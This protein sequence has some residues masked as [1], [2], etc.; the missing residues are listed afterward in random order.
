[1]N[2]DQCRATV[3]LHEPLR[4][5]L[6][7]WLGG[8]EVASMQRC[9]LE[10]GHRGEHL[11]LP[12]AEG[13]GSFRWDECGFHIGS[14]H[15]QR[16]GLFGSRSQAV[17]TTTT[18]ASTRMSTTTRPT[19]GRHAADA[20]APAEPERRSPTQALWALTAAVERLT[21]SI[22]VAGD[23]AAARAVDETLRSTLP[24]TARTRSSA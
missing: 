21:D 7:T 19:G 3:F 6:A 10:G 11:G 5:S 20:F 12:D 4:Q 13:K 24:S 1:M 8:R 2:V 23:Q 15:A 17:F 18:A 16:E 14:A 9:A 22:S